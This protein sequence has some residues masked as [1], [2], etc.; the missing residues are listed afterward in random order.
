M[1]RCKTDLPLILDARIVAE[2]LGISRAATYHLF[3]QEEFPAIRMGI[4][5][6]LVSRDAF[7]EWLERQ[8][9]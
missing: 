5:R 2:I 3:E 1:Y 6:K 9:P 4:R 7:F 8:A